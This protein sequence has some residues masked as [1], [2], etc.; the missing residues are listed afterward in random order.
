MKR[1]QSRISGP[2]LDRIDMSIEVPRVK[3]EASSVLSTAQMREMVHRA[4]ERQKDRNGGKNNSSLSIKEL[5]NYC[6]LDEESEDFI[7]QAYEKFE[8]SMRGYHK[9]LKIARTVADV[10][11]SENININH[12]SEALT[13]RLMF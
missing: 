8:M 13:Y 5:Q 7:R 2:L 3:M 4:V 1:Y 11:Q 12:L 6:E 9:V 10:E